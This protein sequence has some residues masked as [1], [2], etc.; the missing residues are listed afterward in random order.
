MPRLLSNKSP[1]KT[2]SADDL[3]LG[4][5]KGT[6]FKKLSSYETDDFRHD[7]WNHNYNNPSDE[8]SWEDIQFLKDEVQKYRD[9]NNIHRVC[10][11]FGNLPS[12]LDFVKRI[13]FE[14]GV[15]NEKDLEIDRIITR[16]KVDMFQEKMENK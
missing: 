12:E 9:K 6:P 2:L 1:K 13:L 3:S 7:D 10:T 4:Y 11:V 8:I 14:F 15:D 16:V 5:F